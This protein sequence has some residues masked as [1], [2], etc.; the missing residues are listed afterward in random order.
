[1]V[2]GAKVKRK[3][4][5]E[6]KNV[7]IKLKIV[8]LDNLRGLPRKGGRPLTILP[9]LWR[10]KEGSLFLELIMT[11]AFIDENKSW[12]HIIAQAIVHELWHLCG[13]T[14]LEAVLEEAR[15]NSPKTQIYLIRM[16][17]CSIR[18]NKIF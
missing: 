6:E 4:I 3:D 14:H 17:Y 18:I 1:M 13:F 5:E 12:P 7:A 11:N 9:M 16:V 8:N 2:I 15:Y 10:N